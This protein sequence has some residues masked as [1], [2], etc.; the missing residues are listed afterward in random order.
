MKKLLKIIV[1]CVLIWSFSVVAQ[2]EVKPTTLPNALSSTFETTPDDAKNVFSTT[3]DRLGALV[4]LMFRLLAVVSV[5]P[6][7]VGGLQLIISQG[8][9]YAE[10]GKKTLF[11]GIV[12]LLVA[13]SGILVFEV[14]L[15]TLV[16]G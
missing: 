12:G 8:G 10:K 13:F 16:A 3:L 11:W 15:S 5:L 2:A 14:L 7:V 6:V 9:S 1:V 4:V